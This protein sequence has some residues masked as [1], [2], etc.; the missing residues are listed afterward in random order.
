MGP[1]DFAVGKWVGVEL[2]EGQGKNNGS[3]NGKEYFKGTGN[4]GLFVR[5]VQLQVSLSYC[6]FV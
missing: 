5:P 3:V 6:V 2:E 1:T 4:K